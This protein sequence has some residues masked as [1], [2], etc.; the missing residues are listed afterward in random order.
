LKISQ[1]YGVSLEDIKFEAKVLYCD[2]TGILRSD[3]DFES[4]TVDLEFLDSDGDMIIVCTDLDLRN[5]SSTL[6]A[7]YRG[8]VFAT[9]SKPPA[10]IN[11]GPAVASASVTTQTE[12]KVEEK[13]V[14]DQKF[15]NAIAECFTIAA[16]SMKAGIT[17]AKEAE[18]ARNVTKESLV[19]MMEDLKSHEKDKNALESSSRAVTDAPKKVKESTLDADGDTVPPFIHGRHTCDQCLTTPVIGKRYHALNLPDYD[20]CESC[21]CNYK[22]T[23]IAFEETEL[24]TQF[25]FFSFFPRTILSEL[26]IL[27]I[28]P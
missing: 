9:V 10:K 3:L 22:G 8:K 1:P 26:M 23:D 17:A 6:P 19:R 15:L 4:V 27:T 12:T 20:L 5:F 24:G 2:T 16:A 28:R 7:L 25:V 11:A 13:S 21:Y 14:D 18:K